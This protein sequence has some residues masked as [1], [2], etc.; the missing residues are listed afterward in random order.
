MIDLCFVQY[1]VHLKS[2][3]L[4]FFNGI[5][6]FFYTEIIRMMAVNL[7]TKKINN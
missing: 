6:I 3:V 7:R 5:F 4:I 1:R 2:N